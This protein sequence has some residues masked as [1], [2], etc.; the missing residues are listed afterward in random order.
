MLTAIIPTAPSHVIT[1]AVTKA[2]KAWKTPNILLPYASEKDKYSAFA[3]SFRT[4]VDLSKEAHFHLRSLFRVLNISEGPTPYLWQLVLLTLPF[5]FSVFFLSSLALSNCSDVLFTFISGK[6]CQLVH[7]WDRC[8]AAT[9]GSS[10]YS[11]SL[12]C[13]PSDW[14]AHQVTYK[15]AL[16]FTAQHLTGFT[17]NSWGPL[18]WLY[19]QTTVYPSV[20]H[21]LPVL[22]CAWTWPN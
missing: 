22:T 9:N 5:R 18:C 3:V 7:I 20:V 1:D 19:T 12:S 14:V 4:W 2:V 17:S 8:A 15:V 21:N 11:C 6:W 16:H 10:T 13:S